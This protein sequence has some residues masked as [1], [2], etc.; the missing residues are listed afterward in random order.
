VLFGTGPGIDTSAFINAYIAP[1]AS[2]PGIDTASALVTFM[3][4]YDEGEGVDTGL[5]NNDQVTLTFAQAWAQF[6]ALPLRVQQLFAEDTLFEVLQTVGNDFNNS[7]SPFF[8]QYA[9]GYQAINTLFPAS[10]GYTANALGG[11]T[12]GA[13][14]LVDTGNLDIRSTTIQTQQ[15]GNVTILGPGGEALV[16]SEDAPPVITQNG[17]V[18]V[19]PGD[20][21]ILTLEQ[22]DVNIFTDQSVLLAQ[23]RI[24]TEEGGDMTI[25][26]SNGDIN[27]G[28]GAKT[29]T[30]VPAPIYVSD[31]D[32]FN[33]RDARGEVSGA[34]IS[35]VAAIPGV[36][37]GNVDLIAPRGTVDAGAAGIRVS[38]NLNIAALQVLN[39]FNIQVQGVTTGVPTVAAPNVGALSDASSASA[40]ATKAIT[41]TGQGNNNSGQPSILIVEIEGYG[42]DDG[43]DNNNG[44]PQDDHRH[45]TPGQQSDNEHQDPN[46]PVQVIG[47]GKLTPEQQEKLTSAEIKSFNTP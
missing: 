17:K 27:A 3:E 15:G 8:H 32:H 18:I 16:G 2:V 37:P 1:G 12:N 47:G 34:G 26:S 7:A 41:A 11:G 40:A 13:N 39:A 10:F 19:G 5:V 9:R 29:V 23:S 38:G 22:G 25:W 21:G 33:T 44:A 35:T 31:E 24:F 20:E 43:T 45:K 46:S 36:L 28:K 4:Q 14:S 6:E 42:G 30:N